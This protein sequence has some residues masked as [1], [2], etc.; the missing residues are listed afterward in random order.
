MSLDGRR[1][2][3]IRILKIES[4]VLAWWPSGLA[5]A[6]NRILS[7]SLEAL[8]GAI[9]EQSQ[10][11]PGVH[12]LSEAEDFQI[13]VLDRE[14]RIRAP[15]LNASAIL[16]D[17]NGLTAIGDIL[18]TGDVPASDVPPGATNFSVYR[19]SFLTRLRDAV[20]T[21]VAGQDWA[22]VSSGDLGALVV[23]D[24]YAPLSTE[25]VA[26]K[27]LGETAT[28]LE[29][30]TSPTVVFSAD[31]QTVSNVVEAALA[32]AQDTHGGTLQT[33][34][35]RETPTVTLGN[36]VLE[37][38]APIALAA[39][40]IE[41]HATLLGVTGVSL[42]G[43]EARVD[44]ALRTVNLERVILTDPE[45]DAWPVESIA[46]MVEFFT[47]STLPSING[48]L[49][50]HAIELPISP[51]VSDGEV[52]E[53]LH[54]S[55]GDRNVEFTP[56]VVE[57]WASLIHP[58]GVVVVAQVAPYPANAHARAES[59]A[60]RTVDFED[61]FLLMRE[62]VAALDPNYIVEQPGFKVSNELLRDWLAPLATPLSA[63]QAHRIA[64]TGAHEQLLRLK[65]PDVAVTV[66]LAL[67]REVAKAQVVAKS[68][69]LAAIGLVIDPEAVA[70]SFGEQEVRVAFPFRYEAEELLIDGHASGKV[71]A[72]YGSGGG[73][74]SFRTVMQELRI[75][76]LVLTGSPMVDVN[77]FAGSLGALSN[78][79]MPILNGSMEALEIV[80]EQPGPY[81]VDLAESA[82]RID[83]LDVS[84]ETFAVPAPMVPR[85]LLLITEE[86]IAAMA[87]IDA[88]FL[89][90]R[91]GSGRATGQEVDAGT[92][93]AA[94]R[95]EFER[96]WK[97]QFEWPVIVSDARAAVATQRVAETLESLW[98]RAGV[99]FAFRG[100]EDASSERQA[101]AALPAEPRCG[102]V[103]PRPDCDRNR[104]CRPRRVCEA[105]RK[106]PWPLD[107]ILEPVCKTVV[108][109]A[110][111]VSL[112]ECVL[113]WSAYDLCSVPFN[114]CREA[115][116]GVGA[117]L[118]AFDFD[119]FGYV[120][121]DASFDVSIRMDDTSELDVSG[122]LRRVAFRPRI[123]GDVV[124][125]A[126]VNF[127]ARASTLLACAPFAPLELKDWRMRLGQ[128]NP[129]VV[130]RMAPSSAADGGGGTESLGLTI[131]LEPVVV[132]GRVSPAPLTKLLMDNPTTLLTC[133]IVHGATAG[134]E[135]LGST[136]VTRDAL[137]TGV[138]AIAGGDQR[139]ARMT[140]MLLDG[141]F[142]HEVALPSLE[143][144]I[145]SLTVKV[146]P[147]V[148]R[149][150]PS[151]S[152][153][154][155]AFTLVREES[156]P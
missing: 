121:T 145:P 67:V 123:V 45:M 140:R 97:T 119:K 89:S 35:L 153:R 58:D 152:E 146:G 20:P 17:E 29:R 83:G 18:S 154:E 94:Y 147:E 51:L 9:A 120:S 2:S 155:V 38:R 19:S 52:V 74:A 132:T 151:L 23:D 62:R 144:S 113:K 64:L 143:I 68:G 92:D 16:I 78:Q 12:L 106:L 117:G 82:A 109:T 136:S 80:I 139:A 149:L 81:R 50:N 65:G 70:L 77:Q 31:A 135:L 87:D 40:G 125:D 100:R 69:R 90:E 101:V 88:E 118:R 104:A 128:Q 66:P 71:F 122:D 48:F 130:A 150:V 73:G 30:I 6:A 134:F 27:V 4:P 39:A 37:A 111:V 21:W 7:L 91:V 138:R 114:A 75:D 32:D 55:V 28:R 61:V 79:L 85:P 115:L 126:A 107:K 54:I 63:D 46:R 25:D 156:A 99:T 43:R 10:V 84:P 24:A 34:R 116:R 98:R 112:D 59:V 110:C 49:V 148:L 102:N 57:D 47:N 142:V 56:L 95:A 13:R 141:N 36:G 72:G 42:V 96:L 129:R 3:G 133:P 108:D 60:A 93:F 127:E 76:T 26:A 8:N 15:S 41:V 11:L 33:L 131:D 5:N 86:R 53:R 103:C 44:A 14:V 1:P 137:V 124:V 105:A 22:W